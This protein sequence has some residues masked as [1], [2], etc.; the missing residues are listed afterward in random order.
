M[1]RLF[2]PIQL[3]LVASLLGTVAPCISQT[4]YTVTNL[5]G[6]VPGMAS[7]GTAILPRLNGAANVRSDASANR[8]GDARS[9]VR[10][11]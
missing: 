11:P 5:D 2:R 6:G 1:F 3:V 9:A 10:E 4:L 8:N 7:I